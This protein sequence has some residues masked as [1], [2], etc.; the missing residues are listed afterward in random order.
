LS[1][2]KICHGATTRSTVVGNYLGTSC[3]VIQCLPA[4]MVIFVLL[5][6]NDMS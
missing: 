2:L 5:C 3:V 6:F 4:L 1:N